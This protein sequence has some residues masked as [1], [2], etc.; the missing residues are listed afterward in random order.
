M[1][2]IGAQ[3]LSIKDIY[4]I[5]FEHKQVELSEDA[6]QN[7]SNGYE[8]LIE[9]SKGKLIYG[10]N[11][12]F[13]PMAQYKIADKDLKQL[14]LNLIRSHSSGV[15]ALLTPVYV[16]SAMIARLSSFM[17]GYSGVHK[18]MVVLLKDLI[19]KNITPCIYEHGGVGASGDLVQLAH[20]ALTLIGEGEVIYKGKVSASSEVFEKKTYNR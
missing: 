4:A 8:F 13:G 10:I 1:V 14:Q 16:K 11:T 19:N 7:V 15:G 9:F 18:D 17:K 2:T 12:G 20:L 3:E 5:L 6:V